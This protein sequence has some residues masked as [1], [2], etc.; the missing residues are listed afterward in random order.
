MNPKPD[1]E[2]TYPADEIQEEV[3]AH[4]GDEVVD[5]HHNESGEPRQSDEIV[6]IGDALDR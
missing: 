6:D 2:D 1:D 5:R 3:R 4:T